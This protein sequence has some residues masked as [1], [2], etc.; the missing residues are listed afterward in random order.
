MGEVAK[1]R[2]ERL[3]GT[4]LPA[5]DHQHG[6]RGNTATT[7]RLLECNVEPAFRFV[8]TTA[9]PLRLL[10][11]DRGG[12]HQAFSRVLFLRLLLLV[13]LVLVSHSRRVQRCAALRETCK[14][15]SC[16]DL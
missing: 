2:F 16:A 13:F 8:Y 11:V 15:C 9:G 4:A 3:H 7:A 10:R 1:G 14:V 12:Y 5:D 6:Q